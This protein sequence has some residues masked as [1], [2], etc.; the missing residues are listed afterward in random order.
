MPDQPDACHAT[1]PPPTTLAGD[2]A[3]AV[4]IEYALLGALVAILAI[5]G[6]LAFGEAANGLWNNIGVRIGGALSGP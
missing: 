2:R 4:A 3:A 5:T 6:M 1:D